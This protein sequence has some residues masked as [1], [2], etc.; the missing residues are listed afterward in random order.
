MRFWDGEKKLATIHGIAASVERAES[1]LAF[2][3]AFES[4]IDSMAR[5]DAVD[6]L[7]S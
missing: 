2:G 5:T 3:G 4:V 6:Y 1:W 7:D